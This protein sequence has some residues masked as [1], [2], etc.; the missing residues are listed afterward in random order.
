[1]PLHSR[2]CLAAGALLLTALPLRHVAAQAPQ[3]RA[4]ADTLR[5]L[6]PPDRLSAATATG[7][8]SL[9]VTP[10]DTA[11]RT[12]PRALEARGRDAA[13]PR[14]GSRLPPCEPGTTAPAQPPQ[15]RLLPDGSYLLIPAP[16]LPKRKMP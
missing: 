1:M 7:C 13:M 9:R 11:G 16:S 2:R 5:R 14:A 12:M 6:G 8:L 10:G 4:P 15:F 3:R